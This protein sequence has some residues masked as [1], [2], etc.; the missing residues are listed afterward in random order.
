ME[1]YT[2]AGND[3]LSKEFYKVFWDDAKTPLLASINEAFIKEELSTSQKTYYLNICGLINI[4]K[5]EVIVYTFLIFQIMVSIL[6][7]T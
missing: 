6:S 1:T 4:S 7:V 3:G 2:K 5:L